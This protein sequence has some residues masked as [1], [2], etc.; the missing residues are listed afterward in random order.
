[1]SVTLDDVAQVALVSTST[2]SRAL[3]NHPHISPSTRQ[4]VLQAARTLG[5]PLSRLRRAA[6]EPRSVLLASRHPDWQNQQSAG[7]LSVDQR[8]VYG[9][10][11]V[12]EQ[13][14]LL[15]RVQSVA[16]EPDKVRRLADNPGVAG[17]VLL[18]GMQDEGFVRRLQASG[19]PF[20]VA[21]A[22][23]ALADVNCVTAD[24]LHGTQKAVTHLIA[25]GRRRI[26]LVNG[27]PSTTSSLEKLDGYR[28]ALCTHGIAPLARHVVAGEDFAT[29]PGYRQTS[30][31]L[32]QVPDLDAIVYAGDPMA[33]GGLRAIKE[34]GRRVPDDVAIVG[35]YNSE[36]A[37]FTEPPLTS[38]HVDMNAIGQI[39]ARRLIAMLKEPD[40]RAWCITVPAS[41]VVRGSA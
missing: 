25:N 32:A 9:A 27:P 24:Y 10:Q 19:L 1:M 3:N 16:L 14:G 37:R 33:I 8:L 41:L 11:A 29:E 6:L 23:T 39:A 30:A 21:G 12:L 7:I 17:L 26:G 38:V 20:V 4:A 34:Q 40:E 22:R 36:L 5:Y 18:G 35:F 15:A 13:R 31:L 28:L 2:V